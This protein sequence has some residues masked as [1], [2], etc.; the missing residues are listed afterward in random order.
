M[1]DESQGHFL[2]SSS[3]KCKLGQETHGLGNQRVILAVDDDRT[4]L[5][6]LDKEGFEAVVGNVGFFMPS[7]EET[8][9]TSARVSGSVRHGQKSALESSVKLV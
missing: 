7:R 5:E 9:T 6:I 4:V 2:G 8:H 3:W 1:Q